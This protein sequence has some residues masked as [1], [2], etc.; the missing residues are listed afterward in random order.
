MDRRS[1]LRL[2]AGAATA[3]PMCLSV[4]RAWASGSQRAHGA[5]AAVGHVAPHWDYE[6]AGA[7]EHWGQLQPPSIAHSN[8]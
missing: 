2:A 5:P 6:G 3:C 7:A 1:I 4:A 8:R